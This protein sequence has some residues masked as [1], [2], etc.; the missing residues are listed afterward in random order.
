VR[1]R[2]LSAREARV[3]RHR[4]GLV[5]AF[6][7]MSLVWSL[8]VADGAFTRTIAFLLAGATLAIGVVTSEAPRRTRHA[9]AAALIVLVA[10][11]ILFDAVGSP[12]PAAILAATALLSAGTI[13]VMAGGLVRLVLARGV[14]VQAVLGALAVYLLVGLTFAALI[15]AIASVLDTAYFAG[16]GG[17][18]VSRRAYFSFTTLTTTGFGDL[19]PAVAV[20]RLLAVLEM[21]IGQLYLVTVIALLVGNLGRR[22]RSEA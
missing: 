5:L 22:H 20:G 8:I 19:T 10:A 1:A 4:Y 11:G 21:L 7:V 17:A 2:R 14:V 6:V 18:G 15:G 9:V 13:A 3:G 16:T 12:G